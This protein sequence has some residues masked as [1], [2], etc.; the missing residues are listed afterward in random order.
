VKIA[1]VDTPSF[2]DT[3]RSDSE[4]LQDV[5]YFLGQVYEKGLKLA[6]IIYLQK[7]TDNRMQGSVLKNLEMF[8]ALCGDSGLSNVVL[9][10]TMCDQASTPEELSK[11]E[12]REEE[13]CANPK[14]WADMLELGSQTFR[15]DNSVASASRIIEHIL[16]LPTTVVLKIQREMV[17]EKRSLNQTVAG[18]RLQ[19]ELLAQEEKHKA[20]LEKIQTQYRKVI[21]SGNEKTAKMFE[22]MQREHTENLKKAEKEKENILKDYRRL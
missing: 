22:R 10:T 2:D 5:A 13:L 4:V 1:L 3:Y 7:I 8:Q 19:K 12:A 21:E 17:D 20:A 9:A 6:G 11:A 16:Q 14:Y 15:H 18:K